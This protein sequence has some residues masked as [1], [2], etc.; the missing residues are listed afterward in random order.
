MHSLCNTT[1]SATA[2]QGIL[3]RS[4]CVKTTKEDGCTLIWQ[5]PP[6]VTSVLPVSISR[7]HSHCRRTYSHC[8]RTYSH[9]KR[10]YSHCKRIYSAT[11]APP[12]DNS[13]LPVYTHRIHSRCKRTYCATKQGQRYL[14]LEYS[15]YKRTRSRIVC[16]F[17]SFWCVYDA[18]WTHQK[19][20]DYCWGGSGHETPS[21]DR[22]LLQTHFSF[23]Q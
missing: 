12:L 21:V 13:T 8:K 3:S 4:T 23:C 1:C 19:E 17:F 20:T 15:H 6:L 5:A 7:L 2:T 18:S 22:N 10:T 14:F 16:V 9:C 11:Q